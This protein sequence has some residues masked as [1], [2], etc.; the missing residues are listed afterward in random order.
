MNRRNFIYLLG[1]G[2]VSFGISSCSSVPITERK[3]LKLIPEANLNAKA[4]KL[5]EQVKSKAKLSKDINTLNK[6][7]KLDQGL[8]IQYPNILIKI[9]N[10]IQQ[11]ISI[12]NIS[13]LKT[14]K[15]EMLGVCLVV[16][17][18]F[19]LACWI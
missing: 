4:E 15:L 6:I 7:K 9:T 2:C 16:K 3:Q 11:Q 17:L 13:L 5:Y 8:N 18:L 19:I 12:G 1:C 10:L 14:I